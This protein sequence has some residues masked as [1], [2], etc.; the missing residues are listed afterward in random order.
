VKNV[1]QNGG[2]KMRKILVLA[3]CMVFLSAGLAQATN[4]FTIGGAYSYPIYM[5]DTV[6]VKYTEGAGS[7]DISSLNGSKLPYLYCVDLFH[8]ISP[9][10]TYNNTDV[11]TNGVVHSSPVN[12]AIQVAWLLHTYG[13]NGQGDAA[14]ALQASIW[15]VISP[16][17]SL[18]ANRASDPQKNYYNTYLGAIPTANIPD[19][20]NN[21]AWISPGITGGSTVY[22]GEVAPTP[23]PIPSAVW[24]LGSGIIGLIGLKRRANN[25][26]KR[27]S[28][29][30]PQH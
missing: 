25:R 16:T 21:F 4:T 14:I 10:V 6:A 27:F 20:V 24:L 8:T 19:Y 15:H 28:G 26:E 29:S 7:F 18:D 3:A 12:N 9:G 11:T 13:A 5:V 17:Y 1:R 23:T 30:Q 22:Q 2:E